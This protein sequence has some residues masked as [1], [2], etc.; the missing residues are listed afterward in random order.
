MLR[1][2][3]RHRPVPPRDVSS[4]RC[5]T[6]KK[7]ATKDSAISDVR[8]AI[9]ALEHQRDDALDQLD[10]AVVAG[11]VR[12]LIETETVIVGRDGG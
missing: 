11:A 6:L 7:P 5:T 9:S 4:G 10:E 1:D 2:G 12:P 8:D 3:R